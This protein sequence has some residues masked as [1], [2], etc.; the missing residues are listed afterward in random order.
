MLIEVYDFFLLTHLL[1][2][3]TVEIY[4]TWHKVN[5]IYVFIQMTFQG[6]DYFYC[7]AFSSL[8]PIL[9]FSGLVFFLVGW[10]C[11]EFWGVLH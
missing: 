1:I 5:I 7:L 8:F 3:C 6:F 9:V 10:F 2:L 4:G 11:F